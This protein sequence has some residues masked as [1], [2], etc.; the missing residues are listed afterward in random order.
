MTVGFCSFIGVPSSGIYMFAADD[1]MR[2]KVTVTG[3]RGTCRL[4]WAC[5]HSGDF[6]FF[7]Y[8]K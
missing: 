6:L 7:T 1:G 8:T 4:M 2:V 5:N 3:R